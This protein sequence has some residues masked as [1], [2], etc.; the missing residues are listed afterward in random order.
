MDFFTLGNHYYF[1]NSRERLFAFGGLVWF[2]LF[3]LWASCAWV[4]SACLKLLKALSHKELY[5]WAYIWGFLKWFSVGALR[6]DFVASKPPRNKCALQASRYDR[7]RFFA[8]LP[9]LMVTGRGTEGLLAG[10]RVDHLWHWCKAQKDAFC[11]LSLGFMYVDLWCKKRETLMDL[12]MK[13]SKS[14]INRS[15]FTASRFASYLSMLRCERQISRSE[16]AQNLT[17][18][19]E[20]P[21]CYGDERYR[22]AWSNG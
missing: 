4:G 14:L 9:C 17:V 15:S 10:K 2:S 16:A 21:C 1:R 11:M 3:I 6:F 20:A 13:H 8:L 7:Y 19:I 12:Q 5:K 22:N 18:T